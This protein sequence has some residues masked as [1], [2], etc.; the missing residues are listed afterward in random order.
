MIEDLGWLA[1]VN[2]AHTS[3]LVARLGGGPVEQFGPLQLAVTGIPVA[4]FN[5]AYLTAPVEDPDGCV[6]QAIEFMAPAGV[7]WLLWVREGVDDAV[8]DA[9]RRAG[10]RDAGGPP[11]M[12]LAPIP[13]IPT[14]PTG[15][16]ITAVVT[17]AASVDAHCELLSRAF[18]MPAEIAHHLVN[19]QTVADPTVAVVIGHVGGEPV[20][21][22]LVCVS[23]STAGVYNVATAP[24]HQRKSYGTAL[25]WA[26]VAE[27]QRRGCNH[28]ILQTS[29]AGQTI[30]EA[31]GF[32]HLGRYVQLEGPPGT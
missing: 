29:P 6:R 10:L 20:S 32:V 12:G 21:T 3:A 30:Y 14:P 19:E 22:A 5:G 7:P 2:L 24:E 23:G 17:D 15:L 11:A 26:A 4:F 1:D 16:E 9:A 28:A 18:E 27:G 13:S 25:T 31:M 8:L